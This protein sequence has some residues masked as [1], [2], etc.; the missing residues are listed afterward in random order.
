MT[1][2][3]T[4]A[5]VLKLSD[6]AAKAPWGRW[7]VVVPDQTNPSDEKVTL[8]H[9]AAPPHEAKSNHDG[10]INKAGNDAELISSYRSLCPKLARALRT[11]LEALKYAESNGTCRVQE[12]KCVEHTAFY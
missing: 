12:C 6:E 8:V 3:E 9:G 11:A 7:F 1:I 5:H 10:A 4:I 2:D